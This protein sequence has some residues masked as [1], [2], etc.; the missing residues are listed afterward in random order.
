MVAYTPLR[1]TS[2]AVLLAV[3]SAAITASPWQC[4]SSPD[5]LWD[6]SSRS[7]TAEPE[8]PATASDAPPVSETEEPVATEAAETGSAPPIPAA[9]TTTAP[10]SDTPLFPAVVVEPEAPATAADAPPVSETDEPVTIEPAET[11]STPPIPAA[12]TTTGPVSDTPLFPT[13]AV[14]PA[15]PT[16]STDAPPV[17]QADEPVVTEPAETDS[18]PPIPAATTT[19]VPVSDPPLFPAAA[20][21]KTTPATTVPDSS[22]KELPPSDPVSDASSE[23]PDEP[24]KERTTATEAELLPDAAAPHADTGTGTPAEIT[25]VAAPDSSTEPLDEATE[26]S[27]WALCPPV[28]YR[29][30]ETPTSET[31]AIELQA[32]NARARDNNIFTMEGN[33]VAVMDWK[34]LE[35]N[36][37]TYNQ[38]EG[39]IDAD[40]NLIYTSPEL[41]VDG[42][43]GTFYPD[44][45]T[46]DI[47][48]ASYALPELHARGT[49]S[50]VELDGRDYQHLKDVSYT[51]CPIESTDWE[52]FARQVDLDQE[53]G[54][55]TARHAK[56]RLKGV[57]VLWTPYMTFPLDDRRKSGLLV[58]KFGYTEET[59]VDISAPYY[60]NIAPDKD[61]TIVPRF[62]TERGV[63]LGGEFRYKN[64]GNHGELTGEYLPSDNKF[65]NEDRYLA[66]FRHNGNPMPR[67]ETS[68]KASTVSDDF[69]FDD[70]GKTLVQTSQTNLERTAAGAY[71]GRGW[72]LG[73]M[74]QNYQ[75]IDTTIKDKNRPYEQLP[76]VLFDTAPATRFLGMKFAA[77][78]EFNQFKHSGNVLIEG[79]RF[80]I[81]PR[82]SLPVNRPGWYIDPSVSVRYTAYNLD[83]PVKGST[84]DN[85]SR[86][87][88]VVSVDAGSFFERS[89]RW[90]ETDFVQTLEPRLFY[91]YVPD[92][93]QDDIP[94]FDTSDYDFNYWNLFRENRFSGPDRMGDAN[95]L[96]LALTSR[97]LNPASGVQQFSVSVGSLLYFRDREVT[98]PGEPV[99]T[100]SSSNIIGELTLALTH[101]WRAT[102]E[103]QWNPHE[104]QTDR[105]S[106][107]LQY[108]KGSRQLVNLAYRYRR[109]IQEQTDVSM[110]WPLGN[111][112]H[113]VGRWYYSLL[114]NRTLE[115]LGG[116]GY[117]SCCWTAQVVGRSFVKNQNQREKAIFFQVELKGLGRLVNT[118]DKELERGILGY[119][120]I[121]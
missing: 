103:T 113:M 49:A 63:M 57:P 82:L 100:D 66:G 101:N 23:L 10:V 40:G 84:N 13:I 6:C 22:D 11:D 32:D 17:S 120:S 25:A 27:R 59:G 4:D 55:G 115:A 95:Q 16:T 29:S 47:E 15:P 73:L 8:A 60:W 20:P 83:D 38:D 87:T 7:A 5:G 41:L 119:E 39:K 68:I 86:T 116:L 54:T 80:D 102:A 12:T 81:Q 21:D 53:D 34:R 43:R 14:E 52:I 106:L 44:T 31:G 107:H 3:H 111:N 24:D 75:T 78:A 98:L 109:D 97:F 90:G 71:H 50:S 85:P 117:E 19:T 65:N 96:A 30:V 118:V 114:D 48:Q 70:F 35:A 2:L 64:R 77:D 58:P 69:Y 9:T 88:P 45:D 79:N 121:N 72:N 61:A 37:I 62:M 1:L 76:R 36:S 110:L 112:W 28:Q 67:M 18:A 105:N 89:S 108:R 42:D 33:A 91:L 56:I 93:D 51:T 26:Y 46:G 94:V 92:K 74:V 99:E 104:S